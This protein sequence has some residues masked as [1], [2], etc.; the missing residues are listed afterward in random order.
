LTNGARR[1]EILETAAGLFA[2]SGY[3]TSLREIAEAS[4]ILPGSLYHHFESKEALVVELIERYR[5]DL[6]VVARTG[7]DAL[8]APARP[9]IGALIVRLG[10]EIAACAVRNRAAMLL[11]LYEPPP[12]VGSPGGGWRMQSP[13]AIEATMLETLGVGCE[14]GEIR[15]G[16]DLHALADRLCQACLHIGLGVFQDDDESRRIADLRSAIVLSGVA[17]GDP[18]PDA[19]LD[20][21]PAFTTATLAIAE[22]NQIADDEDER[23]PM[24]RGVA[25]AEFGLRGYEATTVRHIAAA[26]GMST[27]SVY[28]LIGSK[29]E[30]LSSIML[31]FNDTVQSAWSRVVESS[32]TCV[33]KLDALAWIN[34]NIVDRYNDEYN[35][36]LA[37]LRE[38]PPS[39]A[40]L[41]PGFS[42]RMDDLATVVERGIRSGEIQL[43]APS[44]DI[45]AWSLFEMLWTPESIVRSLGTHGAKRLTR[46][47]VLRGAA[48][49]NG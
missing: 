24:L 18:P 39:S 6:D 45:R 14:D 29:D 27:G 48:A 10:E 1:A 25:R 22:W 26:A 31:A 46:E 47:T 4:G 28:R 19:Q 35:I 8:H 42:S 15:P 21:S 30:L 23:L 9:P 5:A 36:Q 33:E 12:G 41:G 16:I 7:L 17:T 44:A 13:R 3:R 20:R 32:S 49:S 34:T 43:D 37:W 40:D 2:S 38:S 11:T